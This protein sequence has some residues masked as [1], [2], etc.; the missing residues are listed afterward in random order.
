MCICH[1]ILKRCPVPERRRVYRWF[2]PTMTWAESCGGWKAC[3]CPSPQYKELTRLSDT[4]RYKPL[5]TGNIAQ[6]E[7]KMNNIQSPVC[8]SFPNNWVT[9]SCSF[10]NCEFAFKMDALYVAGLPSCASEVGFFLLWQRKDVKITVAEG[11]QTLSCLYHAYH[12][13][14]LI[15]HQDSAIV[16]YI[17]IERICT[18]PWKWF[19]KV[20]LA[21]KHN[22]T[23]LES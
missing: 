1:N 11:G 16:N 13:L 17:K 8:K 4:H 22:L 10:W 12:R 19:S 15:H 3:L 9:Y 20:L 6:G 7:F 14:V 18:L 23:F 2:S 5:S 21:F